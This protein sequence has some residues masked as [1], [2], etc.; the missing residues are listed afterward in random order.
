MNLCKYKNVFGEANK[1]VHKYK[2]F[3]IPVVHLLVT[4]A[5]SY[6]IAKKMRYNVFIVFV[7]LMVASMVLS[8]SLGKSICSD[9]NNTNNIDNV[10]E[11][12]K[13]SKIPKPYSPDKT[14]TKKLTKNSDTNT[15][16]D[17]SESNTTEENLQE[18]KNNK[19]GSKDYDDYKLV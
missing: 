7:V 2:I 19:C 1:S 5:L 8:K 13:P 17:T 10:S 16:T 15:D 11:I 12:L 3:A 9:A 6:L 18:C 4:A 14:Y